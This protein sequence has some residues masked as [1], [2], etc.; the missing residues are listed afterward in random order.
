V[1]LRRFAFLHD[2]RFTGPLRVLGVGPSTAWVEVD[3]EELRV[4]F[5]RLGLRTP[6][7]NVDGVE[8]TGPYRW[9]R[10]I[11]PR[12]SLADHGVT[13]GTATHGGACVR[14]HEPV[15][16]LLGA[17][18]GHPSATVTVADPAGF[19]AALSDRAGNGET[20]Q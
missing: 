18:L 16:A 17:R 13:F 15:P 19:A 9:Y 5:G 7:A 1:S 11:G 2:P 3:E 20:T 10:A 6:R 8:V 12:L 4:R 14:F